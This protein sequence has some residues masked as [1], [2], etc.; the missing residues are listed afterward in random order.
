MYPIYP[1]D[2][3]NETLHHSPD[4]SQLIKVETRIQQKHFPINQ[5]YQILVQ[6]NQ[7]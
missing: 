7:F 2:V 3:S 1:I 4:C 6:S 5:E